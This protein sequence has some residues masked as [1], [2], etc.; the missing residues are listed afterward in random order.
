MFELQIVR[1][2]TG[3]ALNDVCRDDCM[4]EDYVAFTPI[5]GV[6]DLQYF[7]PCDAGC[8]DMKDSGGVWASKLSL[9]ISIIKHKGLAL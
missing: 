4:C 3:G 2:W 8:L 6:N 7:S 9:L 5:C 1:A